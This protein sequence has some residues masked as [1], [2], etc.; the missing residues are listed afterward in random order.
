MVSTSIKQHC[1]VLKQWLNLHTCG[2][3][4]L[5]VC[6]TP[7]LLKI[8]SNEGQKENTQLQFVSRYKYLTGNAVTL[9]YIILQK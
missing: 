8:H 1:Y 9:T 2:I 7:K 4:L 5:F 6:L 3:I